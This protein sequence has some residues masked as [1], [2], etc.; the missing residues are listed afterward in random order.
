MCLNLAVA[1]LVIEIPISNNAIVAVLEQ[2]GYADSG[3]YCLDKT[4]EMLT[5]F[6]K[7]LTKNGN[8][9]EILEISEIIDGFSL[10]ESESV[11]QNN[12]Q[13]QNDPMVSL[14]QDLFVALRNSS[15]YK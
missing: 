12:A 5:K 2:E 7:K 1:N 14:I 9:L 6:S 11:N 8:D 3:G 13:Q 15:E 10:V 4:K